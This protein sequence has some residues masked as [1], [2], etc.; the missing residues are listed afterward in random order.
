[1]GYRMDIVRLKSEI[2]R[3]IPLWQ[4]ARF[5]HGPSL[6]ITLNLLCFQQ[7]CDCEYTSKLERIYKDIVVSKHLTD[8]YGTFCKNRYPIGIG[9]RH[10]KKISNEKFV[11]S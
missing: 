5:S 8:K 11:L 4:V 10:S 1:M 2:F 6:K 3:V 9:I 7:V